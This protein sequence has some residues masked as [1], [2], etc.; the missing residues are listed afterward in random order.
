[1]KIKR[2]IMT[3]FYTNTYIFGCEKKN[4]C[5]IIDPGGD[6]DKIKKEIEKEN[7]K[8]IFIINTHGHFDHICGNNFFNLPVYIHKEDIE[9]LKNP[10]KNLSS[11]FS[12]PYFCNNEILELKE[13]D[14]I[15]IGEI[16]LEVIHTPGHTPGSICL[17]FGNIL[18][19][20]DTL[21]AE[22]IGRTDFPESDEE[23][24]IKSIKEKLLLLPE[25]TE[26]YPGHGENSNIKKVKNW[27][28]FS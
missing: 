17:K 4:V 5:A 12:F 19:T 2:V 26:I 25:N 8:P 7:L 11:L 13:G 6:V 27:L 22:G 18:F 24:L 14:E 3:D 10:D 16:K 1:M 20:G 15:K 23:K 9:F 21:F 28:I